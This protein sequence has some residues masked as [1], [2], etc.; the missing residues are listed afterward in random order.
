M[1][2]SGK[3]LK[4][5]AWASLPALFLLAAIPACNNE[6]GAR[7][8]SDEEWD[9]E[10]DTSYDAYYNE[11]EEDWDVEAGVPEDD[12]WDDDLDT[13]PFEEDTDTESLIDAEN[14]DCD[15]DVEAPVCELDEGRLYDPNH[16]N[17]CVMDDASE[18]NA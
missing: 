17:V 1:K 15:I 7:A 13:E 3:S 14:V 2:R 8:Y 16:A 10:W 9:D 12:Y 6:L 11:Y 4:H 5:L 18:A